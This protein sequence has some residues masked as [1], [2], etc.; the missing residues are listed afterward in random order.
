MTNQTQQ[1]AGDFVA[2]LMRKDL[3]TK[4]DEIFGTSAAAPE[5]PSLTFDE[6]VAGVVEAMEALPVV[7]YAVTEFAEAGRILKAP[8]TDNYPEFIVVHPDDLETVRQAA[9]GHLLK[10]LGEFLL[11]SKPKPQYNSW[12]GLWA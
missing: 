11:P 4:T 9:G 1:A 5:T 12:P 10:P 8:P 6:L 3:N 7:Y 2:G